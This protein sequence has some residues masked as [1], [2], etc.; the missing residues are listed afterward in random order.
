MTTQNTQLQTKS[1]APQKISEC[2]SLKEFFELPFIKQK[3]SDLVGQRSAQFTTSVMQVVNSNALL[4]KADM[5]SVFNAVCMATTLN[6]PIQNS[7]GFAY[8]VPFNNRREGK[9]EA[10]FQIGYKGLIQLA[11]RSGQFKRLVSIPVY[12]DQLLKEDPIN[13]FEFDWSAKPQKDEVPIGYYAYF[14][15]INDFSAELYMTSEDLIAH[16]KRYSQ[17]FKQNKGV[18]ADNFEAM[19]LKTVTKLLLSKQA[20][21]SVEMQQATLSDQAVIKDV[22]SGEFSY[23][24]NEIV[25]AEIIM[26]VS[27]EVFNTLKENVINKEITVQE[28]CDGG[29]ELSQEQITI[30]EDIENG[31]TAN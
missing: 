29:Y 16:A 6:L 31:T 30:L 3:V 23:P 13:G 18:W 21:L 9:V 4:K 22:E 14:R 7:L 24:D 10:Q 19:A 12:K 28:I 20:P 11:Q 5:M 26:T 2:K 8:I 27:D 1:N 15:L 17:T 25:D